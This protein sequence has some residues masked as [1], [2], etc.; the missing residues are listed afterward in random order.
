MNFSGAPQTAAGSS[1]D[2]TFEID[3]CGW[4]NIG[5]AARTDEMDWERRLGQNA[6][7]PIA[8][9]TLGSPAGT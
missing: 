2:C 7:T 1:G 8:D 3:E 4:M 9:H 5:S 6:K